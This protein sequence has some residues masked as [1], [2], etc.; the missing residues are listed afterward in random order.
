MSRVP[1]QTIADAPEE[2]RSL[3]E[4]F[5]AASP[6]GELINLH[7][8]LAYAPAVLNGYAAMR[9]AND[10]FG[11]LEPRLRTALMAVTAAVSG[12][13][14]ALDITAAIARR[15]GWAEEQVDAL[16][17]GGSLG[18][19]RIDALLDLGREAAAHAGAVANASWRRAL[20]AGWPGEQVTEAFAY[21]GFILYTAYFL[22]FA[23]TEN[24][25]S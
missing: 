2:T 22:N 9:R 23:E 6:T 8:Q 3:L 10:Q 13:G 12:N 1:S 24:D 20:D 19:E 5:A 11:T 15:S 16:R 17:T 7:A 14:Y 21:V 25:L 4:A 18:D